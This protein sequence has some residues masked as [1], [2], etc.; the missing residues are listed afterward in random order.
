[1]IEIVI[2][3]VVVTCIRHFLSTKGHAIM[4]RHTCTAQKE[5]HTDWNINTVLSRV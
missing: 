1:M 3:G 5:V 4:A 2:K